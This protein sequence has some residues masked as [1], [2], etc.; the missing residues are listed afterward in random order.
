M[1][2]GIQN[3]DKGYVSGVKSTWHKLAQY[4]CIPD[5]PITIAEAL[6]VANY[7]IEKRQLTRMGNDGEQIPVDAWSIV[8]SDKDITL[9]P[10]VGER[11]HVENNAF[12]MNT[13]NEGLLAIY[14]ELSIQ[15][16]GTLWNGATFFANIAINEFTVKGDKS[17]TI[18]NLM[19]CN[20]LGKGS[21]TACAHSTRV[22]CANTARI[23]ETQGV[24]NQSLKKFRH[25]INSTGKVEKHLI[26]LGELK[27]GLKRHE[28]LL[29]SLSDAEMSVAQVDS[30][31]DK[32]FEVPKED[33]RA[34]TIA[35]NSRKEI[36]DIYEGIQRQTL[37][38]PFTKYGMYQAFT[39]WSD[40]VQTSRN[41]DAASVMYDGIMGVRADKKQKVLELLA[42]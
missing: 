32:L 33:G 31:L 8:R 42:A 34:K 14:P 30:F 21:I 13:I 23:A 17:P 18:T 25:T 39:D 22:V 16:I 7:P 40:H 35:L 11:F 6:E 24:A 20:P 29:N 5:R 37:A 4:V 12:M 1:A 2:H 9:V 36:L 27:L 15:S 26:D 28:E 38:K 10:A 41:A 19:Y 3:A